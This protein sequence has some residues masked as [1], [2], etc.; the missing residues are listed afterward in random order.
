MGDSADRHFRGSDHMLGVEFDTWLTAAE[1][2]RFHGPAVMT[3]EVRV[4][5]GET[6]FRPL[7]SMDPP[8]FQG[9]TVIFSE[10]PGVTAESARDGNGSSQE[11]VQHDGEAHEEEEEAATEEP[12]RPSRRGEAIGR[13][14]PLSGGGKGKGKGKDMGKSKRSG[15]K[16]KG[17]GYR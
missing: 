17:K 6:C 9:Y 14:S 10:P 13:V 8:V 16:G 2:S 1:L 7:A 3:F 12:P 11:D 15:S 5:E 4:I